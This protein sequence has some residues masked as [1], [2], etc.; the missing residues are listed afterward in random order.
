MGRKGPD[1]WGLASGKRTC[2]L[3]GPELC[4][5]LAWFHTLSLQLYLPKISTVVPRTVDPEVQTPSNLK[6]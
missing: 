3:R 5:R 4:S 1:F 6:T 2:P